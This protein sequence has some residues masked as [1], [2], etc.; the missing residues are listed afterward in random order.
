[1]SMALRWRSIP[2]CAGEPTARKSATWSRRVY[3]RVCGGTE[4]P[5]RAGSGSAGLSPRVRGNLGRHSQS[6][7]SARSI[8]ACAGE[9]CRPGGSA[10]HTRVYPRVCGGTA[11][12]CR[13]RSNWYG[14]SPRV[15]GNPEKRIMGT[16]AVRSIPACAGEP[17]VHIQRQP[18]GEV[19]PRVCG[20][21]T[22]GLAMTRPP[23]GLSP[24]VRGNPFRV[25]LVAADDGSIPACAGEP[26]TRRWR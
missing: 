16:L 24:R 9:P 25:S 13:A 22:R 12:R 5:R 15:R 1:M 19:Y 17:A 21:T 6:P 7:P 2:A 14:L 10:G 3:P 11:A 26:R 20:G 23:G 8:P 18:D 4:I